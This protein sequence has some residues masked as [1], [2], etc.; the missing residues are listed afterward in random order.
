MQRIHRGRNGYRQH[1]GLDRAIRIHPHLCAGRSVT[2]IIVA[3]RLPY[4][5]ALNSLSH[6]DGQYLIVALLFNV[7]A[8]GLQRPV[9]SGVDQRQGM[10]IQRRTGV[11]QTAIDIEVTVG[12]KLLQTRPH[13]V[14][15]DFDRRASA[16]DRSVAGRKLLHIAPAAT[17]A[18][19][20]NFTGAL[21]QGAPAL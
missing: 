6:I 4:S 5:G 21:V 15:T 18:N 12:V 20:S 3:V 8:L 17:S 11:F 7:A 19:C 14:N 16:T 10:L 13:C 1:D 9:W 2:H